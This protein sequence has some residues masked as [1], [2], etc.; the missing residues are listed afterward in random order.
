MIN[1]IK[2]HKTA[3]YENLVEIEPT[4][5]NYFFGSN[6]T[7][8][9]SLGNVIA[10]CESFSD[11][12]ISWNANPIDT[13]V[14]NKKFVD[15]SFGQSQSI[16]GIF[17]LGKDEKESQIFIEKSKLE[18]ESLKKQVEGLSNSIKEQK[19]KLKIKK[20]ETVAKSWKIKVKFESEFKPAY[21]G[22]MGS[23]EA[24]FNK[25]VSESENDSTLLS[26][27]D[28]KSKCKK[29]FN[30]DLKAYDEIKPFEFID[31]TSKEESEILSTKIIGKED[32]EIGKLIKQLDNSDWVKEGVEY[33]EETEN[34][35]PFCQQDIELKLR[36]DIESFFDETY[37]NNKQKLNT[38]IEEYS[39][40]VS[41][42]ITEAESISQLEIPILDFKVLITKIE[43]LQEHFKN[44]LSKLKSK[45]K[46]P[47][48]P[49]TLMSL[50]PSLKSISE[51][52]T[53]FIEE[54][55]TNNKTVKNIGIEK[56][57]LKSE[58]W[59]FVVSELDV[60]LNSYSETKVSV[61]KAI[62]GIEKSRKE[63][64]DKQISLEKQLKIKEAEVTS[65]LPTVTEINKILILFGFTNFKLDEADTTGFYKIV[66]EDGTDVEETLS[67]GEYTF[68]TFLYFYHL[69]K[70]STTETGLANDK[71]VVIDDPISSLDSN[72]LF[73][74]SNLIK[75][76]VEDVKDDKNGLKQI[77]ILT[78]NVYFYKEVTFLGSR[79]HHSN[80]A[81]F[82]IVR[83]LSNQTK[84]IKHIEN[85]IQTTYELL[86]RELDDLENIN[87]ATIFNTLRRILEYYFN[88]LGGL[89]YEKAI[90]EFEG[91]EQIIFKSLVSWINDGSHFINDD[92]VV[93]VEPES[94]EKYLKV[95]KDIFT[96]LEH[97]SHYNMMS[98]T[99]ME[100]TTNE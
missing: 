82:W 1:K 20:D 41:G 69:L 57:A 12:E 19:E 54:I 37:A 63:K 11:C 7:G 71:V 43:L 18:I 85:P 66:R 84:I 93:F 86:W 98:R 79:H 60:D 72:I 28:I 88:I 9:T 65:V 5:V 31:L 62:E 55:K 75:S 78:H 97:E 56:T 33:L 46:T 74:V 80:K 36:N 40:Y 44:N 51:L 30:D 89:D 94:I 8:K 87:T 38:F 50:E 16:Q 14:Y 81:T 64:S 45:Q 52:I 26:E 70:G 2:I 76:V 92:L 15:L 58:I 47:S 29:V 4:E 61:D 73:V 53:G 96:K 35:C 17:T 99:K 22:F 68:V 48:V 83:K 59:R 6:G 42:L 3:S 13:L 23:G 39:E 100:V 27:D 95:F 10:D 67:E 32:V 34:K 91:E 77:F 25:C 24:F 21:S 90:S 49:I